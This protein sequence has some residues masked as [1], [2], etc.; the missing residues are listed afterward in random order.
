MS[1]LIDECVPKALK[2]YLAENG[3]EFQTVQEGGWSG[4]Q[5]GE[6]LD[7]AKSSFNVLVTVDTNR[8]L[9]LGCRLQSYFLTF[10]SPAAPGASTPKSHTK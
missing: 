4:K 1:V 5:N 3:Y 10:V 9:A 8:L 6:L 7:L 2:K